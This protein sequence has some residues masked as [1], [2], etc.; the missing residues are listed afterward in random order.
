M[1]SLSVIAVAVHLPALQLE[2]RRTTRPAWII[3]G[4]V[5]W[6]ALMTW[7]CYRGIELSAETQVFLLSAEIADPRGLL[8]RGARQ[9]VQ[10]ERAAGL[11]A[12]RAGRGSTR[13]TCPSARS[14]TA[15]CSGSSSTGAGTRAS[16]STRSHATRRK[17]RARPPS[18][19]RILLVLIYLVVSDGGPGVRGH[20]ASSV[21]TTQNDVLKRA[22]ARRLRF[23][24]GQASDHR[25]PHVGVRVDADDDPADRADDAVDGEVEGDPAD[26]FGKIHPRY[27]TPTVSTLGMGALSTV[28]TAVPGRCRLER[29]RPRRLDHGARLLGLLLLRLHRPRVRLVLP[30]GAVQ[31]RARVR[32]GRAGAACSAA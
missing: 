16:P 15:C 31:E 26:A 27:L 22:R 23:A 7:I 20:E 5:V 3:I 12:R 1:A 24:L 25:R 19:R 10:R 13:S 30:A 6:I 14:S 29:E 28:W 4:A 32:A 17:A 18:S 21:P 2:L 11:A 8:D 9:D